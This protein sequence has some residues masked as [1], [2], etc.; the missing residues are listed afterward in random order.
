MFSNVYAFPSIY[1]TQERL[2]L[3]F[4]FINVLC[5]IGLLYMVFFFFFSF[6][7]YIILL[8]IPDHFIQ[9]NWSNTDLENFD[10]IA[11]TNVVFTEVKDG[12]CVLRSYLYVYI[13]IYFTL[14]ICGSNTNRYAFATCITPNETYS[15]CLC[16]VYIKTT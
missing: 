1:A 6:I 4:I 12:N 16:K 9:P 13:Y 5:V 7:C 8:G 3:F 14:Y 2:Y 10:H 15:Q 11:Y